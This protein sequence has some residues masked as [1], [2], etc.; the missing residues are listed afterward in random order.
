MITPGN[1]DRAWPVRT[2]AGHLRRQRVLLKLHMA[3]MGDCVT[4]IW[5]WDE[6]A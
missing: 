3:A 6:E 4:A 1:A 5:G 2:A